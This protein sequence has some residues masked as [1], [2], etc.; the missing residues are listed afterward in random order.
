MSFAPTLSLAPER[1]QEPLPGRSPGGDPEASETPVRLLI[2]PYARAQDRRAWLQLAG[3]ALP[4]VAGWSLL[5]Y[6]VLHGFN[7]GLALLVALPVAGLQIR[8]FIFQH[9][10][11]HGSFFSRTRTN[12]MVGRVLGV[13]T[14]IPYGY[15][16]KTHAIHHATAGN[17][18]RRGY[19]DVHTLTVREYDALSPWR[20]LGYRFYRSLPVLLGFGPFYQFVVKHR[21]PLDLPFSFRKEWLSVG[22]N[23]V[24]LAAVVAALVQ[25]VGLRAFLF[26]E[27]TLVFI[28]GAAG[29][30]LFYVQHQFEETYWARGDAW[31]AEESALRGSSQFDLPPVLHWFTGNIGFHHIHHLAIKVPNYRLQECFR[32]HPRLQQAP[33]LTLRTSLRTARLKLWDEDAGRMVPFPG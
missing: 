2:A 1:A 18:D 10:C 26:V 11:G 6:M 14:L 32:S 9:D 23:N 20:R 16:R 30:W 12:D 28:S 5:A 13:V 25:T 22:L 15:W 7:L 33:R 17:I 31:S 24:A 4:F 21:L 27:L 29:V 3:T 19:G 8:L